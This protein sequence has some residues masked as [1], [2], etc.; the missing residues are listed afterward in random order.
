MTNESTEITILSYYDGKKKGDVEA[1]WLWHGAEHRMS[2]LIQEWGDVENWEH[3]VNS[4]DEATAKNDNL[5]AIITLYKRKLQTDGSPAC[6][7]S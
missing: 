4:D 3:E 6:D 5:R 7:E 1:F 2:E